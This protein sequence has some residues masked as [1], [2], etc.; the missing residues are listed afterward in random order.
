M[1]DLKPSDDSSSRPGPGGWRGLLARQPWLVFV[2]PL[3]VYLLVGSLEPTPT[4]PGGT[5]VGWNIPYD[6]YPL[7]Y[8][9]KL[10]LTAIAVAGV[11]PGYAGFPLRVSWLSLAVGAVGAVLWVGICKLH[12][13][14]KLLDLIGV[15]GLLGVGERSAFNP[16]EQYPDQP[17]MAW[18]FL[19]LRLL[20]L[21]VLVPI[22]EE[23]FL[24]AFAMR[25]VMAQDWW[26]I[27]FGKVDL[28][29]VLVGTG[30]PMLMHP[31]EWIAAAVWFSMITWLMVR[32]R[33]IWDC[34]AA[35]AVTNG[36]LGA[37]VLFSGDWWLM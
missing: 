22:I 28:T 32:T 12:L 13:E 23:F 29:A 7:V 2:L 4:E 17:L 37:Y 36:L 19:S 1:S 14:Q 3:A 33:N 6:A 25:F 18:G 20:G 8:G 34:I 5:A 15:S 27:P 35:H 9:A 24:R 26:Q 10:L 16:F 21:V 11:L 30:L 31:G